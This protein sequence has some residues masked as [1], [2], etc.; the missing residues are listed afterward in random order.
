M[1]RKPVVAICILFLLL[2]LNSLSAKSYAFGSLGLQFDLAQMGGTITKDGLDSA[3]YYDVASGGTGG[4][5]NSGVAT[6]RAVI[7]ENRLQ[8]LENTTVGLINV[9]A[10]G[11][12]SGLVFSA[13]Y[14]KDF[15]KNF[16]MRVAV[17]YTRKYFGG[18]TEAKALGFKFYDITWD[19]NA[20][21]IP[22]NVG[23]KI[24]VSED[25]ALYIGGGVHYFKGGW[26]L[27]GSNLSNL[28]HDAVMPLSPAVAGLISDGTNP[29]AI[30]ENARFSVS[31]IA[32]N[33]IIGAQSRITEKGFI[34]M[35]AETLF[36]YKLGSGHTQSAGGILGLSPSPSYP[37]VLGGTQYRVG[38]KHEL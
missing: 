28:V 8:T 31:G 34:Y 20:V 19:Y 1:F 3:N 33:W 27:A 17:N 13:G 12:M 24:S 6:R 16:F 10:N 9:K 2:S 26:S 7:P 23:L 30:W 22:I 18:D 5:A 32:P 25:N 35:E 21:Q 29:P 11:A 14:E 38:Y 36:S 4:N 37:I 15:A